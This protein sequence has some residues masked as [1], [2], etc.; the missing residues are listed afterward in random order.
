MKKILVLASQSKARQQLLRDAHMPYILADHYADEASCLIEGTLQD[1]VLAIAHGK[2]RHVRMP[3][4][5]KDT[6]YFVLTADTMVQ[7]SQGVIH[8]KPVDRQDAI[9]R[10]RALNGQGVVATAFCLEKRMWQN[11]EWVPEGSYEEVVSCSYE[12][13]IDDAMITEYLRVVPD[14]CFMSGGLTI[15]GYGAQFVRSI[16]GSYTTLLG[17]PLFE[18]RAGLKKVGFF[19][20]F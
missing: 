12:L 9:H 15:E 13:F 20:C 6:E 3:N 10:I 16:S 4:P 14:Y 5:E 18:V 19:R 2:M 17:L 11:D 1:K 7:D 8:G